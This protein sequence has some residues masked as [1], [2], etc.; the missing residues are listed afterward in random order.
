MILTWHGNGEPEAIYDVYFS[1]KPDGE[2]RLIE[3][4][5]ETY[6]PIQGGSKSGFYRIIAK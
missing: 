4:T 1:D 2:Y 5:T 3:H 6:L